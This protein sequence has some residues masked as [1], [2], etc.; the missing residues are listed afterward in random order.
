MTNKT[1]FKQIG[2]SH[3]K[4]FKISPAKFIMENNI[5][6]AE[7]KELDKVLTAYLNEVTDRIIKEEIHHDISEAEDVELISSEKLLIS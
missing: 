6:Y 7:F 4:H 2:G 5:L 1:F 3:Y